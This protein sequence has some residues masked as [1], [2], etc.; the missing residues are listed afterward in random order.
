LLTATQYVTTTENALKQLILRDPTAAAWSTQI[1]PTDQPPLAPAPVNLQDALAE[2]FVNRP[3]LNR[4]RLQQ[5]INSIDVQYY[6]NQSLTGA[7]AQSTV[8]PTG[9]AGSPLQRPFIAGDPPTNSTAFLFDQINQL[10]GALGQPLLT[11]PPASN[12]V[13]G[14]LIGGYFRALGNVWDFH[15]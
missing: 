1:E 14:N 5:E 12:A 2:A 13:P 4:L 3:E 7:D 10:R 11:I 6:R 8:S 15:A 9:Y